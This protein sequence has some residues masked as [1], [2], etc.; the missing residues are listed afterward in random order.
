MHLTGILSKYVTYDGI[1]ASAST[2][3]QADPSQSSMDHPAQLG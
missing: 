2:K 3:I 1:P